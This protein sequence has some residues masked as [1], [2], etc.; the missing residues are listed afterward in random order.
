M[1]DVPIGNKAVVIEGEFKSGKVCETIDDM[2]FTIVGVQSK[3]PEPSVLDELKHCEVVYLGLDPD[4]FYKADASDESA[5]EYCTRILGKE[6]VRIVEFP[7]KPDDGIVKHGLDPMR[8]IRMARK[9]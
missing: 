7:C 5:V 3:K 9:S 1:H 2:D 8:Y 6:R 4:A